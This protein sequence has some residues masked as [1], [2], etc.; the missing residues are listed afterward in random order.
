M[1]L[2]GWARPQFKWQFSSASVLIVLF[3]FDSETF[4]T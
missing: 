3:R 2:E 4:A 1:E